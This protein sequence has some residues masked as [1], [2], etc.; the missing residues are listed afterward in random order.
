MHEINLYTVTIS[1]MM[2]ALGNLE[3]I[4]DKAAAHAGTKKTERLDFEHA[5]LESRLVFDQFPFVRQV[6]IACDNGKAAAARLSG[7]E[8][9][10]MEDTEKTIAELKARIH[11]TLEFMKSV[12]PE[13]IAGRENELVDLPV[14]FGGKK[15]TG[16]HYAMEYIMPNF[17]FHVATAYAILRKNGI[18]LGK[19]DFLGELAMQ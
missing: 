1:P 14:Y 8:P 5:L 12:Q 2:K 17:Y 9:P 7:Q 3:K 11:K 6:Q 10:V 13:H 19:S 4:L 18:A 16:Y 15:M